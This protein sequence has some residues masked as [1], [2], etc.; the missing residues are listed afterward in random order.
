M[1]KYLLL[2]LIVTSSFALSSNADVRINGAGATFPYPVYS[3]WAFLYQ[4]HNKTWINYQSIGSGGGIRQI[5]NRTVDFGATDAPLNKSSQRE[6]KVLQFPAIIGGVVPVYNLQTLDKNELQL[7]GELLAELF[8]GKIK[9]WNHPSIQKINPTI[10]LPDKDITVIH[11][12]DGSGT[13][14]IFTAYLSDVSDIWA[15]EIGTGKS[16]KWPSGIGSKGNEG[17][18]NYTKR[19]KNSIGYVEFAYAQQNKLKTLKLQN[20][21]GNFIT[22]S[23]ESF[24]DAASSADWN[25]ENGFDLWLTNSP[26]KNAWPIS[27]ATFIL[28]AKE[29]TEENKKVVEFFDWCF[30]NGDKIA[31]KLTY[32]PLPNDLKNLIRKYWQSHGLY[33][34]ISVQD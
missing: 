32:V 26:G 1:L 31:R 17:V 25:P 21:D 4:R 13:T 6:F 30:N 28:L 9:K 24:S 33:R 23:F 18:A 8:L 27:G 11:R 12:S 19:V 2:T 3:S 34:S 22:P 15:K 5:K 29:K 10:E 16:V 7:T 14:S 20:K